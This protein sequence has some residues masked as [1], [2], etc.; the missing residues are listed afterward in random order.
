MHLI[1]DLS[2]GAQLPLFL[3]PA[4]IIEETYAGHW[5]SVDEPAYGDIDTLWQ[6]KGAE[7]W[8]GYKSYAPIEEWEVFR[9]VTLVLERWGITSPAVGNGHHRVIYASQA[10]LQFVPVV[11]SQDSTFSSPNGDDAAWNEEADDAF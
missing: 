3:D 6:S 9:P 2:N 1:G 4:E 7:G 8:Q 5:G 10:G 11:W